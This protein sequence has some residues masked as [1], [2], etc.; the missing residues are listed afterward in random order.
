MAERAVSA[1]VRRLMAAPPAIVYDEWLDAEALAEF[2]CP[3]PEVST[4]IL[5]CD[6]RIG[7]R[8]SVVMRDGDFTVRIEGEY[9][10]LDR[11]YRLS[12]TWHSDMAGGFES[13]VTV[14]FE[15]AGEDQTLMTIQHTPLPANVVDDQ[16]EGWTAI[17]DLLAARL[18]NSA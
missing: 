7:G 4:N 16:Q 2:L 10:E 14:T 8:L 18:T 6:P 13:I 11:P 12:F 3:G 15:P 9:Q 5:Q 17:A 1:I